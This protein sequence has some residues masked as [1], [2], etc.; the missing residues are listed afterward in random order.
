MR[1]Q[2][3]RR[4]YDDYDLY[5]SRGYY[6][7]EE[8]IVAETMSTEPRPRMNGAIMF[9]I[10]VLGI[11]MVGLL[12]LIQTSHVA[13]LGYEV[14]RLERE[15]LEKSLENQTLTYEIARFQALPYIERIALEDMGMQ[16]VEDP[17]YLTV[18]APVSDELLVP[19]PLAGQ[20]R[21]LGE[22]VWDALMGEAAATNGFET[23]F[24]R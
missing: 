12:Y 23:E 15:R 10:A 20:G 13:G 5:S 4:N 24:G 22:R 6:P 1:V 17:I 19:E 3:E 14:S 16:P 7:D 21:S 11:T 8:Y 9:T 2:P 18:Q